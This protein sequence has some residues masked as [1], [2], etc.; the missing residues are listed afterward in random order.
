MDLNGAR[1]L[2]T[3]G[4]EGI[5]RGIAEAL[6][7]KGARA[8]IMSRSKDRVEKT[9]REIGAL[10]IQGDVGNEEHAVRA[11]ETVAREFGGIDILV[12]NAG[13]G[14]FF[15]LVEADL[16]KFEE[17]FRTN[18]TGAMLM[19]REAAKRFVEQGSGHLINIS[20]TSGLRGGP[21]S[22]AYSGSKFALRGMTECWRNELRRHNVRVM[23]VNPSEV[24][25]GF[26]EKIGREQEASPKKLR[27]EEI[28]DAIVG[29]LEV[30]D[31]GFIP[32]FSVFATNPF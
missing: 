9:A 7:R 15:P 11:V 23:L 24:Q 10:P 22:T 18:V 14:H 1:A 20:S 5:G 4:S 29:A 2:V 6:I 30:D 31:R 17:V 12:N 26:F 28:A 21:G 3:G 32:E 13:F 27:P 8:A 16:T 25:T 19:A